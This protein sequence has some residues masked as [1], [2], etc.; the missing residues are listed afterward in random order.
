MVARTKQIGVSPWQSMSCQRRGDRIR[1]VSVP[2]GVTV[3]RLPRRDDLDHE[4]VTPDTERSRIVGNTCGR[5][6]EVVDDD[7]SQR[8]NVGSAVAVVPLL[9]TVSFDER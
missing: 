6:V 3:V 8:R 7:S 2:G 9:G 5:A 4:V 1:P